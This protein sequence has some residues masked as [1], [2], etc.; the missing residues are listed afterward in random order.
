M[1]CTEA[2]SIETK[3]GGWGYTYYIIFW[4]LFLMD[5]GHGGFK[6]WWRGDGRIGS[7]SFPILP[8]FLMMEFILLQSVGMLDQTYTYF[9]ILFNKEP[10]SFNLFSLITPG[11]FDILNL[12]FEPK[13]FLL[14]SFY[15][16]FS[17]LVTHD[18][19]AYSDFPK[20]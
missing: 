14:P 12:S 10:P 3:G 9:H 16:S 6:G 7:A 17:V 19:F 15:Q 5:A 2:Q 18:K 11:N 13:F 4:F 20:L 8:S 1:I